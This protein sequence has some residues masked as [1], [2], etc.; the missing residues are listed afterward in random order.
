MKTIT[1]ITPQTKAPDRCNI[2]LDGEFFCG[3]SLLT[4]MKNRLKVGTKIDAKAIEEIQLQT[5]KDEALDKAMTLLSSFEK[6]EKQ[7]RDYLKTKGYTP[8]VISYVTDKLCEYGFLSDESFAERYADAYA[9]KK[10]ARL[11]AL[12]L[13]RKGIA[14][15][16]A[17]AATDKLGDQ[18]EFAVQLAEK[19][20]KNKKLDIKTKQKLYRHL[21]SKGFSYEEVQSAI[22]RVFGF[23]D[24][25][26]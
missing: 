21:L 16:T 19:Y 13:K 18:T 7:V 9:K 15:D 24:D 4:V 22:D 8:L 2:Y 6:T 26:Q 1:A 14:E 25:D 11:I 20:I 17:T 23:S 5:E 3:M 12:E 10:G